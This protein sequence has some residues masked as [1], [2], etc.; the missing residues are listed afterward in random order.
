MFAAPEPSSSGAFPCP[1]RFPL[2]G[3]LDAAG[4]SGE[5]EIPLAADY[6]VKVKNCLTSDEYARVQQLLGNGRAALRIDGGGPSVVNIDL[7]AAMRE[8]VSCSVTAWNID[9]P[10]GRVWPLETDKDKR[11]SVARLPYPVLQ[12]VYERC[13][14]LNSPRKGKEAAQFPGEGLGGAEDG[15]GGP[16]GADPVPG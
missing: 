2:P 9:D 16:P 12:Q 10:D 5:T 4:Y 11:V 7:P 15:D 6:W 14:E 1:R 3:F 8:M 13:N